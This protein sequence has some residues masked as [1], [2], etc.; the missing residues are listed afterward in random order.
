MKQTYLFG[1]LSIILGLVAVT[2]PVHA[3]GE[4]PRFEPEPCGTF[5]VFK[6]A[7]D[8]VEGTDA[9]C[10]Y[11]IVPEQRVQPTDKTIKLGIV[12]IKSTSATPAEPL[13]MAQGGP[14]G[15][16]IELYRYLASPNDPVGQMLR[17][18]R[19]LIAFEQ[20]G[21][22]YSEPFL[23]CD[24]VLDLTLRG[25]QENFSDE[26]EQRLNL[27]AYNACKTRLVNQGD[28]L[29]AFNSEENA[30]D[31]AALAQTLGYEQIS[32]YGV[33]YGTMLGQHLVR[34]HPD[35]VRTFTL[36][37]IVP[38]NVNAFQKAGESEN[39]SLD[40]LFAAC[41]ADAACNRY[42]PNLE[43]VLFD[44]VEQ[45]N[46]NPIPIVV[47][48][49]E[50]A[51]NYPTPFRGDDLLSTVGQLFY[52]TD[53]IPILPKMIY[54][55]RDRQVDLPEIITSLLGIDRSMSEGMYFSVACAEEYFYTEPEL[56]GVRPI[57]A[58]AQIEDT[59]IINEVC[60]NWNVPRLD[61]AADEPV[62]NDIPA[63]LF[64]G[65]FDP[66]T[67]PPYG[68]EVASHLSK[69]THVVFPVNGHGAFP[70]GC[71][72]QIMKDFLNNPNVT[73]DTNCAA[74][75]ATP[76]FLTPATHLVSPG[77]TY[78]LRRVFR[79]VADPVN[80]AN[81]LDLIGALA[82][83]GLL[84]GLIL[85]FPL[86]WV[87]RWLIT[88]RKPGEKRWPA[89]LAPWAVLLWLVIAI[90]FVGLQFVGVGVTTFGGSLFT[91]AAGFSR[92]FL[93]I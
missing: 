38:L 21:T 22:R 63:L 19:D 60:A 12:I 49:Q 66:I 39:R 7:P 51:I 64:S 73:P 57:L 4:I 54:D 79:A 74:T 92:D 61:A 36:D 56:E 25:F 52:A 75:P 14:G 3:Q 44:T 17:A 30:H 89:R 91:A 72:G 70:G 80:P 68:E 81:W 87:V 43:Q 85:L 41:A 50:T 82:W 45:L 31:V 69:A 71:S 59:K 33:S 93:W 53:A 35:V 27:E 20:R 48:D 13:V 10:G 90:T 86:V 24:E 29:A 65:N 88:L 16:S 23:F 84:L 78:L 67:P 37:A 46:Q 32:F 58:E 42:Y 83:R 9:E 77:A 28:N 18:D 5:E 11:L 76:P 26:E 1:L 34:L 62:I 47:S 55:A 6:D 2:A 15:S 40:L 8:A